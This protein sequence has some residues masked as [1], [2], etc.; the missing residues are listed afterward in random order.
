MDEIIRYHLFSLGRVGF[1][2]KITS[3]RIFNTREEAKEYMKEKNIDGYIL[4]T[5]M[6]ARFEGCPT[7]CEYKP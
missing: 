7:I 6:V 3:E 2:V 4:P 5:N 1:Q